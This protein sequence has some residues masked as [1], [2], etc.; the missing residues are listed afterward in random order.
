MNLKDL[1]A[2]NRKVALSRWESHRKE[3]RKRFAIDSEEILISKA[4]L[5]GFLAGDG[6]VQVRKERHGGTHHEIW[7]FPDDVLMGETYCALF[8]QLFGYRPRMAPRKSIFEVRVTSKGITQEIQR[9]ATLGMKQWQVPLW[10]L[11]SKANTKAWLK[12]FFSAE[13]YVNKEVIRVQTVNEKGMTQ[14]SSMLSGIGISH[15]RYYYTPK[16]VNHSKVSIIIIAQ[17]AARRLYA[18]EIGV[19]HSKK[20]R[21]LKESLGL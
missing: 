4:A 20:E 1:S 2:R 6:S 18:Q 5:C 11:S 9:I 15:R 19:W 13:G 21:V 14:I 3:E 17:K 7:F 12:A 10:V 16:K 8:H